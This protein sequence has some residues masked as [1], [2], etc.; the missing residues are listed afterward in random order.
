MRRR[1]IAIIPDVMMPMADRDQ[2]APAVPIIADSQKRM[3]S[4]EPQGLISCG[5]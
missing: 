5:I 2:T 4:D 3:R 1:D